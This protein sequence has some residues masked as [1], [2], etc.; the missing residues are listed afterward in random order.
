MNKYLQEQRGEGGS[1]HR[2]G[3][4]GQDQKPK[5]WERW[6]RPPKRNKI[7]YKSKRGIDES[8]KTKKK[9]G[10]QRTKGEKADDGQ[11]T[12]VK[13]NLRGTNK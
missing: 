9:G 11:G 7:G 5:S 6:K 3:G 10:E 1:R 8:H 2:R 13:T 4:E 12:A